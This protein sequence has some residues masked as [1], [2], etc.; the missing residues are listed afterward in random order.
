M[1]DISDVEGYLKRRTEMSTTT[2]QEIQNAVSGVLVESPRKETTRPRFAG[3]VRRLASVA[4]K[5]AKNLGGFSLVSVNVLSQLLLFP[6]VNTPSPGYQVHRGGNAPGRLS[7]Y[8]RARQE[9]DWYLDI[10]SR[11]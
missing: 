10:I 8:R 6:G 11:R 2:V 5:V 1:T 7:D 9:Y 3:T 4:G